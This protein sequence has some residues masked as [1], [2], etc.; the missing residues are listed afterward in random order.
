MGAGSREQLL[1]GNF[2]M[3]LHTL[4]LVRAEKT[5]REH[6]NAGVGIFSWCLER[7]GSSL[8]IVHTYAGLPHTNFEVRQGVN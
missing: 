3:I 1:V 8:C 5:F 4:L 2:A 7:S 6:V